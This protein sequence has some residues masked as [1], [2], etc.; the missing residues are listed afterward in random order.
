D[1]NGIKTQI[2][3][4]VAAECETEELSTMALAR[5]NNQQGRI[6]RV[7]SL[8]VALAHKL[9]AWNERR[10]MRDLY[11][12]WFHGY[13]PN[14]VTTAWVGFDRP[15]RIR[16][17]AQGGQDAAPINAEV[18]KWY[19]E[20][21]PPPPP[22]IRP[23]TLVTREVDKTTGL[24]ANAWCP[25]EL[26]YSE[27]YIPGTEPHESCDIHGPWGTLVRPGEQAQ[28]SAAAPITDGFEF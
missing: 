19:Y 16:T 17:D 14:L 1:Y 4:H 24:L 12:A 20:N 8:P 7:M 27:S 25:T 28:D 10:L 9:A 23:S 5:A 21:H 22:W 18:L 11:D 26:I 2:E 13:T 3:V 6:I 15:S